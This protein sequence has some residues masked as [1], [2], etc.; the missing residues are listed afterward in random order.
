MNTPPSLWTTLLGIDA[1]WVVTKAQFNHNLK[2]VDV[3]IGV[4]HVQVKSTS[5]WFGR[6]K[7]QETPATLSAAS[8]EKWRHLNLA[9]WQTF[10]HSPWP[11]PSDLLQKPWVGEAGQHFS[12]A[13]SRLIFTMMG[14]GAS[15][16]TIC[17]ALEVSLADLWK[18]KLA[19]DKGVV[20]SSAPLAKSSKPAFVSAQP[21]TAAA[22]A[23]YD[24]LVPALDD[25]VWL[26]LASGRMDMEIKT[27]S[28]RL[29]L[30]RVKSQYQMAADD[31]VRALRIRELHRFFEKNQRA[32]SHELGQLLYKD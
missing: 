5:G 8:Y 11:T 31:E 23:E 6:K 29:L 4:Q 1:P 9:G 22:K 18:F 32:L 14:E 27:L 10:V 30:T 20:G 21:Q 3:W 2:R 15:L 24:S 26:T 19:L 7:S 16:A 25:A 13:Q 17:A 12:H 28:L